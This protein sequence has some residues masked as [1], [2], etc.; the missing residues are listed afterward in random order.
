MLA[1]FTDA[2]LEWL[3]HGQ[4][5]D[6]YQD[7]DGGFVKPAIKHV[8]TLIAIVVEEINQ[9]GAEKMIAD[10]R[11][12][13]NKFGVQPATAAAQPVSKPQPQAAPHGEKPPGRGNTVVQFS[14]HYLEASL[15]SRVIGH[16]V[17]DEKAWQV[18]QPR[19]PRHHEDK[20]KRF[21][22]EHAGGLAELDVLF[23]DTPEKATSVSC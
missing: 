8:A 10:E 14:F 19:E 9:S 23:L 22:P 17:V 21:D 4:Y 16:N 20:V 18:E 15:A 5:D 3:N 11:S 12:D 2:A 7:Q 1:H 6:R 13:Q